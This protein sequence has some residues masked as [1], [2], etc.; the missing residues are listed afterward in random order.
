MIQDQAAYGLV[1]VG[2][3][4]PA[5]YALFVY[6]LT[7]HGKRPSGTGSLLASIDKLHAV[8]LEERGVKPAKHP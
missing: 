4:I 3:V 1:F 7:R 6:L 8:F 2:I 5:A